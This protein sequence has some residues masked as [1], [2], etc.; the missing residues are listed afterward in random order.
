M[1]RSAVRK[2][3]AT[4][5]VGARRLDPLQL[6]PEDVGLAAVEDQ[7]LLQLAPAVLGDHLGADLLVGHRQHPRLD[8]EAA[9][10]LRL[11]VGL[12]PARA[13]ELGAV[14]AG[15]EVAVREAEPVRRAEVRHPLH[16]REGVVAEAPAA[17]LVDFAREPVADQVGV[18]GDVDAER[19]DVVR[20]VGDDRQAGAELLL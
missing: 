13:H 5:V 3:S 1:I 9:R 4:S 11:R 6:D 2:A 8:P 19:L 17:L 12:A 15:G 14:E 18:G 20:R 16:H 10:D 7:V